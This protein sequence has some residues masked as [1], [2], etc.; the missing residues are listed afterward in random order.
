MKEGDL[1]LK[2]RIK[3]VYREVEIEV[4]GEAESFSVVENVIF[5]FNRGHEV[6]D[7]ILEDAET[8]ELLQSEMGGAPSPG[9]LKG[10]AWMKNQ[11]IDLKEDYAFLEKKVE[12]LFIKLEEKK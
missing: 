6:V 1:G 2:L 5:A 8:R 4:E 9:V 12:D 10:I 3:T 7:K 11:I